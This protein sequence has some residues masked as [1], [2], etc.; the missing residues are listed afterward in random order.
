[1]ND[2]VYRKLLETSW[3][4]PLTPEEQ[5]RLA[6]FLAAHADAARDWEAEVALDRFLRAQRPPPLASNFTAQVLRAVEAEQARQRGRSP[7]RVWWEDWG[8]VLAPRLAW[9]GAALVLAVAGMQEYRYLSRA[10]L[11]QDLARISLVASVPAP[12]ILQ[13]F[14]SIQ[15][16]SF[17]P[18][19]PADS[20]A[21]SDDELLRAL[22]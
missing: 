13:D 12:E 6:E 9:A 11:A 4:R 18:V 5:A 19:K 15:Q 14:E 8:R 3:R 21:I 16:L 10:R 20:A 22:Q 1:M 7:W 17:V 2:P